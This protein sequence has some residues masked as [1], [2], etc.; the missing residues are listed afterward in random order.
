MRHLPPMHQDKPMRFNP[1]TRKGCD[2][3]IC[4]VYRDVEGF[5]PRTRKGCD[6][7]SVIVNIPETVSTHAPVKDAT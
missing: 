7:T 2:V 5:N 6:A 4:Q 1:R 3:N